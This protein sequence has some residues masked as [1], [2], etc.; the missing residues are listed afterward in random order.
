MKK[1][2]CIDIGGTAVK[3]GVIDENENFLI[4]KET[5]TKAG[6]R[7]GPGIMEC[8]K[9]LTGECLEEFPEAEGIAVSTAGMVDPEKGE[10][11]YS[12]PLIPEWTGTKIKDI[13]EE[14]FHIPCEVENDVNCAGLAES[15]SGAGKN[16]RI[17][18]CLTIGTGIGGCIVINKE[19]FYGFS[20]SA[21]EVGYMYLPDGIFQDTAASKSLVEKVEKQKKLQPGELN[22]KIIFDKAM[23]GDTECIHAIE[24]MADILGKGIAN[25]C[26]VLNPEVVILGGGIM[27]RREYWKLLL[28]KALNKYL[29][30]GIAEKTTLTFAEYENNAGMLGAFYNYRNRQKG[31][32]SANEIL[33]KN[34]DTDN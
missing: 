9:K 10:I 24:E 31:K 18:V 33:R 23:A 13:L 12:S 17:C 11:F 5:P 7:K 29:V 1:Y 21:C 32:Q 3:Y 8:I 6:E 20:N 30:S 14:E 16:A 22:G 28:I 4:K 2:I 19:I 27:S 26:Y 34:S 25:I 15:M